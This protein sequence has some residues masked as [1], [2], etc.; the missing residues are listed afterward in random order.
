MLPTAKHYKRRREISD[1]LLFPRSSSVLRLVGG[2]TASSTLQTAWIAANFAYIT[3]FVHGYGGKA[4]ALYTLQYS[5]GALGLSAGYFCV[6]EVLFGVLK[7][8]YDYENYYVTH[9]AA[10]ITCLFPFTAVQ[11]KDYSGW[12]RKVSFAQGRL[13]AYRY[14]GTLC[15]LSLAAELLIAINRYRY[16]A[17]SRDIPDSERPFSKFKSLASVRGL[18]EANP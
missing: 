15:C 14:V 8:R 12:L 7:R 11:C 1:S 3:A 10:A 4:K 18:R 5:L 13:T 16:L 2:V 6:Y 9:T 17:A